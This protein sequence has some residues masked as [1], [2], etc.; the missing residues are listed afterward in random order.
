MARAL[1]SDPTQR[2]RKIAIYGWAL[3]NFLTRRFTGLTN[4]EIGDLFQTKAQVVSKADIK[5]ERL[6]GKTGR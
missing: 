4:G 5:I 3:V 2:L 6:R 1:T